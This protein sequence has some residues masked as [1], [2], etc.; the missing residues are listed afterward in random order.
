MTPPAE[1]RREIAARFAEVRGGLDE[2]VRRGGRKPDDVALVVVTKTFPAEDAAA[3]IEAGATDI[4]E[5][6]VQEGEGKKPVAGVPGVRWHLIGPLQSNK[7]RRALL[8]FDVIETVDSL[9]LARRIDRIAGEMS[10]PKPVPLLLD[11]NLGFEQTKA[12][13]APADAPALA[14]SLASL[15]NIS[16][17]GLMAIPPPDADPNAVRPWVRI[18]R[19]LRERCRAS[20]D[21]EAALRF[22]HLSIGMS[23]DYAEAAE[24]GATIVRVGSAIFGARG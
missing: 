11:V 16:V 14:A 17:E 6:R 10:L 5:N 23:H 3:A 21:G 9:D 7:V 15:P 22:R 24:E 19:D 20:L 8:T 4:G 12:G 13:L 1:R 18:L 2:A